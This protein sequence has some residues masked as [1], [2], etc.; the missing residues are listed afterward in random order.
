MPG[1]TTLLQVFESNVADNPDAPFLGCRKKQEDGSFGE[2]EWISRQEADTKAKSLARGLEAG[3]FCPEVDAEEGKKIRFCGL[4]SKNRW[5]WS[6]TLLACM[7]YNITAVGFFDA[8]GAVQMDFILKQTELTSIM[9]A[10]EYIP[11]LI[12]MKKDGQAVHVVN[13]I[14]LGD[15]IDAEES[16]AC[17]A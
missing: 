3:G 16:E 5:E 7:H 4:W 15:S 13:I 6:L 17:A 1:V 11:I 12:K 8:M 9:S 10:P 2:Y 14:S